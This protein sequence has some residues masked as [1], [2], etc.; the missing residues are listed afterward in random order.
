MP[1]FKSMDPNAEVTYTLWNFNVDALLDQ[2][3]ESSIRPHIFF[4]LRGYSG[5]WVHLLPEGK[6]IPVKE[7][8]EYMERMFCNVCD[9]DKL[10]HSLYEVRQK[11]GEIME[12]YMLC[13]HEAVAVICHTYPNWI[14][15]QGKDLKK[16]H[17]YHGLQ[18]G[19]WNA[20]SFT[21]AD[22]PE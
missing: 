12:E 2:Y 16:D 8:L 3:E 6:D 7:M 14:P 5:K 18:V 9:Y 17:F 22:L 20:L 11:D 21:M 15:N 4:N 1:V 10:I 19:L 13:I